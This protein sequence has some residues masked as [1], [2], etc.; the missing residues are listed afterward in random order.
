MID[1]APCGEHERILF[2]RL[3]GGGNVGNGVEA[4]PAVGEAKAL[5]VQARRAGMLLRRTGPEDAILL[6]DLFMIRAAGYP[7][8]S[9][10]GKAALT[11]TR[12]RTHAI[13]LCMEAQHTKQVTYTAAC[14]KIE[15]S[16]SSSFW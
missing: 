12:M 6:V 13:L 5:L 15:L 8:D 1:H 7:Y 11:R 10:R 3:F 14:S 9:S 16:C 2:V 4:R